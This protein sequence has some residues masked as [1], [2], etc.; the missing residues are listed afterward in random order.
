[1]REFTLKFMA[2]KLKVP[3]IKVKVP[4]RIKEF[5]GNHRKI[6]LIIDRLSPNFF[7]TWMSLTTLL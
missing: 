2:A 1:M 6:N 7:T 4:K 3:K 5:A